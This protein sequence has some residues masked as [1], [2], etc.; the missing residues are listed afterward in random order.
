MDWFLCDR[1]LR[2][3]RVKLAL[4]NLSQKFENILTNQELQDM[5]KMELFKAHH[6]LIYHSTTIRFIT[7]LK[8]REVS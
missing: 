8:I 5:V 4:T 2:H 3:E 7:L 6:Y 1:D